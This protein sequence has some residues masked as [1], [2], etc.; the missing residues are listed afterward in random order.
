M[1]GSL[2]MA[3]GRGS[4]APELVCTDCGTQFRGRRVTDGVEEICDTCYV[5]RF[6]F[7]VLEYAQQPQVTRRVLAADKAHSISLV[8][9][10]HHSSQGEVFSLSFKRRVRAGKKRKTNCRDMVVS[11]NA[12]RWKQE[13]R[14]II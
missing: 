1:E 14:D 8:F 6:P 13:M 12:P 4:R 3:P 2:F 7:P 11:A 9:L 5:S 10:A